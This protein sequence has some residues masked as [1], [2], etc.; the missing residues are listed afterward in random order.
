M[1]SLRADP[2]HRRPPSRGGPGAASTNRP[3]PSPSGP[4]TS[5]ACAPHSSFR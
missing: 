2:G 4:T 5:A 3:P 1:G